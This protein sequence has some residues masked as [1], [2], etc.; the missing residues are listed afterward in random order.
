MGSHQQVVVGLQRASGGLG[1]S[2]LACAV[3]IVSAELGRPT[4]L[5]DLAPHGGGLDTVLGCAHEPGAR[6]PAVE[7]RGAALAPEELPVRDGLR[8]LSHSRDLPGSR[9]LGAAP[10]HTVSRLARSHEVTVLD[11]PSPDHARAVS[12]WALCDAVILLAGSGPASV[13]AALVVR[14]LLPAPV[15]VLCRRSPG[16]GLHPGDVAALLGAPLLGELSRD[17]GVASA[18]ARQHPPGAVDGPL[19]RTAATVLAWLAEGAPTD[20]TPAGWSDDVTGRAPG[21]GAVA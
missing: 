15:A 16:C 3:A 4:L 14:P 12:W 8:V 19:R 21:G 11:L 9:T 1:S 2:S 10:L 5:V 20:P 13:A 17:V 7:G 18:L 6:W